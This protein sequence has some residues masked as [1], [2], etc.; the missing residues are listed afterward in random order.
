[1]QIKESADPKILFKMKTFS[2][3]LL[4]NNYWLINNLPVNNYYLPV[5]FLLAFCF[6]L[7]NTL[8]N[9]VIISLHTWVIIK[10]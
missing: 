6:D 7:W 2:F 9:E 8:N 4:I 10:L 3:F 1:M 5:N